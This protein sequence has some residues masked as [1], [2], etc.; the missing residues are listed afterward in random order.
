MSLASPK[1]AYRER[2]RSGGL[3]EPIGGV[4]TVILAIL[5]L[6]GANGPLMA[7]I[8]T[9][10]FGAALLIQGGTTT[11]PEQGHGHARFMFPLRTGDYGVG[12]PAVFLLGA[13]G[14]VLGVLAELGINSAV[15]TPIAAIAFGTALVLGPNAVWPFFVL[16]LGAGK[17]A[18]PLPIAGRELLPSEMALGSDGVQTLAGLAA[19]VLGALAVA[20][21]P[22]D[23]TFNLIALLILGSAMILR[24]GSL[25]AVV[26]SLMRPWSPSLKTPSL[27]SVFEDRRRQM[28]EAKIETGRIT[29]SLREESRTDG[30]REVSSPGASPDLSP[31]E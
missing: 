26:F 22:N 16:E 29:D 20:N 23:L 12:L 24:G 28:R 3:V 31:S 13:G 19:I 6:A 17:S 21:M 2:T 5:G 10:V 27:I 1:A 25:N 8:A 15:L 30:G 11:A 14:L 4:A 18:G 9:I 7:V